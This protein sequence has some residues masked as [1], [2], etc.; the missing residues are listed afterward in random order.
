M[1][2]FERLQAAKDS[3][4]AASKELAAEGEVAAAEMAR[5]AKLEEALHQA[6]QRAQEALAKVA[7]VRAR[8]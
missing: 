4:E 5:V 6:Q 2:P 3:M 7:N 1:D 8:L